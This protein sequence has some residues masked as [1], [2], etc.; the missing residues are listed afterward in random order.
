MSVCDNLQK[1]NNLPVATFP[2]G[3]HTVNSSHIWTQPRVTWPKRSW[4][5]QTDGETCRSSS[6][7]SSAWLLGFQVKMQKM[8]I[9]G[10][11]W[12]PRRDAG[13]HFPISQCP[14][15]AVVLFLENETTFQALPLKALELFLYFMCLLK[16]EVLLCFFLF[17][18]YCRMPISTVFILNLLSTWNV[19][20]LAKEVKV[21][22]LLC[23]ASKCLLRLYF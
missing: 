7:S 15:L 20:P 17:F 6:Y 9:S 19:Y 12:S 23:Q 14:C 13:L 18:I 1:K 10:Q 3:T 21:V 8:L 22:C 5:G 2:T 11:D 4:W 16:G